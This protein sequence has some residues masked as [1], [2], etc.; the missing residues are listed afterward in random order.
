Y[1]SRRYSTS[2]LSM[3]HVIPRSRGGETTWEN[4]V[5]ACLKCNVRKGGR[6]PWEAGMTLFRQP[7]RPRRNPVLLHQ[8]RTRKY[9]SW[10][11]F[12]D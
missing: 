12:L 7:I 8:L 4:I 1:C 9:S 3:D 11:S 10:K 5:C 6:T 2:L